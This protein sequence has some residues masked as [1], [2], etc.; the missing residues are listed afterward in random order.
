MERSFKKEVESLKLGDGDVFRG[1][2]ILLGCW[3]AFRQAGD[4]SAVAE[5]NGAPRATLSIVVAFIA[6]GVGL[7]IWRHVRTR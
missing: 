2:G 7:F 4:P 1:E 5:E 6:F 3:L